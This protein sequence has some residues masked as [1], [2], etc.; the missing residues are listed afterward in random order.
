MYVDGIGRLLGLIPFFVDEF[1][2]ELQDA[3]FGITLASL[4]WVIGIVDPFLH[5]LF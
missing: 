1:L 2:V 3:G 4:E 5:A